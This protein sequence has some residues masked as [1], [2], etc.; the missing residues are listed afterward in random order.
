MRVDLIDLA[1]P[2][3]EQTPADLR[4]YQKTAITDIE[5]AL[6]VEKAALLYVLPT[7]AGKTVIAAEI[8]R[9]A[10]EE[11]GKRVLVLTHRREILKQTS[12][13][14]AVEHGLIQAGLTVD[15]SYLVQIGSVQ[16]L[17]ERCMRTE[18]V[19]LPAADLIVIDEAHHVA[20]RTWRSILEAYPNACRL[21]LTATPCRSDGRGL[22]NYFTKIIEGPQIPDLIAQKHLVPDDLLRT[23]RA[24]PE[25]SRRLDTVTL[26]STNSRNA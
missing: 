11:A 18:K 24:R 22:G 6:A 7:G 21:G 19:P 9:R 8:I 1:N 16:T 13:K 26:L 20:A 12:F 25:R 3:A 15:L 2:V 10:A 4:P 14:M 23:G 17:W 5:R